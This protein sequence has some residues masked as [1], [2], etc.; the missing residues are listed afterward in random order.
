MSIANIDYDEYQPVL[1]GFPPT[2]YESATIMPKAVPITIDNKTTP[3]STRQIG[4]DHYKTMGVQP[5]EFIDKNQ[6]G[7]YEGNAVKYIC[8]H[9]VKGGKEDLL[10]AIHYLEL[11][12]E[13]HYG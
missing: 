11:A 3:A 6:L 12:L 7:W 2:W 10:K 13:K 5:S 8:R 9:K 4:G 1:P